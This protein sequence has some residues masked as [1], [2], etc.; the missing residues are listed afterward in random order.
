MGAYGCVRDS[1]E[2][3]TKRTEAPLYSRSQPHPWAQPGSLAQPDSWA[4]PDCWAYLILGPNLILGL[5]TFLFIA[6]F[7]KSDG[8]FFDTL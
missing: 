2:S 3:I 5:T 1:Y 6:T 8:A 4:R 7:V